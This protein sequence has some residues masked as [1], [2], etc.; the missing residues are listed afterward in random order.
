MGLY[1]MFFG[2]EE[3]KEQEENYELEDEMDD[4]GLDDWEKDEVRNNDWNPEDFGD[5]ELEEDDYYFD[6]D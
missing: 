1:E 4:L 6:D 5:E 2:D 3:S